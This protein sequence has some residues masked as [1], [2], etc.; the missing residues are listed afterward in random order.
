MGKGNHNPKNKFQKGDKRAG[1][2]SGSTNVLTRDIKTLLREAA[3]EVG[4]IQRVREHIRAARDAGGRNWCPIFYSAEA[5]RTRS[6]FIG[7]ST[8]TGNHLPSGVCEGTAMA[9]TPKL[10]ASLAAAALSG[11]RRRSPAPAGIALPA[12]A[13]L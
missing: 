11:V 8:V 4:F 7:D 12:Q 3:E 6:E 13:R 1:R 5:R 9:E 2:P 10:A